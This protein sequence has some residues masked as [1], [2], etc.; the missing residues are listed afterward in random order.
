[1]EDEKKY[2]GTGGSS[3]KNKSQKQ[4]NKWSEKREREKKPHTHIFCVP[5]K[6]FEDHQHLR[7]HVS[8]RA[9]HLLASFQLFQPCLFFFPKSWGS[10]GRIKKLFRR[11]KRHYSYKKNKP[12]TKQK[13]KNKT[14]SSLMVSLTSWMRASKEVWSSPSKVSIKQFPL[15]WLWWWWSPWWPPVWWDTCSCDEPKD[16]SNCSLDLRSLDLCIWSDECSSSSSLCF[17]QQQH[18]LE[19]ST[20]MTAFW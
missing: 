2:N 11:R 7:N 14:H 1:M 12:K 9:T 15:V 10:W 6:R 8:K 19:V 4:F 5:Q 13:N 16:S 17:W 3:V 18:G 20:P